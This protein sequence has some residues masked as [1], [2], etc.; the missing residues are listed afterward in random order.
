MP[1]RKQRRRRE[2]LKRHEYEEVYVDTATGEEVEVDPAELEALKPNK[3]P[4]AAAGKQ[5]PPRGRG[6]RV[7]QPPSWQRVARRGAIFGP[8]M[9]ITV[10]LLAPKDNRPIASLVLQTLVLLGFFIP[11]SYFMDRFTYNAYL[12]RTAKGPGSKKR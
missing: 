7:I 2:K 10:Y 9:F 12:R 8:F 3:Q 6:G 11:F 4:K 5:E 1:S